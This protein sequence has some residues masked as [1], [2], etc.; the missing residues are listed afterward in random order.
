LQL[1]VSSVGP[2]LVSELLRTREIL[3]LSQRIIMPFYRDKAR[4]CV[5]WLRSALSGLPFGIHQP[6][7][8]IFLWLWL[9][10]CPVTSAVLYQELKKAGV[11]VMSGHHF[12][13][14]IETHWPHRDQ[15]LRISFAMDE[16]TVQSGIEIIGK[17]VRSA[18]DRAR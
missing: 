8:A 9:R 3:M 6:E 14:G 7:G 11:L 4:A 12:F 15:C 18:Y 5:D 17:V 1:A 2:V 16:A 13:P 10:D